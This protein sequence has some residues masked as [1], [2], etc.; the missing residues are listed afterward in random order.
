MDDE[1]QRLV[2][3]I[4]EVSRQFRHLS[5]QFGAD[6]HWAEIELTMPQLKV[7]FVVVK[8]NG[9]TMSHLARTLGM[10]M[11]TATGIA[12]RLIAQGLAQRENDAEDR[13]LVWLLPTQNG[14]A[15]VD[16]LAQASLAH[17]NLIAQR[18]SREELSLVAQALDVVYRAALELVS[19]KP[20]AG[21]NPHKE[22][23]HARA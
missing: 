18:L 5:L 16:R 15:L 2:D 6:R 8:T 1:R 13:R 14:Y 22:T 17:L 4:I 7:L 12:D 23:A 3:H 19:E 11:S 9:V 21:V 20:A 10:T